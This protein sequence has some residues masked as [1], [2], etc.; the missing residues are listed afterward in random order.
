MSK[1]ITKRM[2]HNTVPTPM[3]PQISRVFRGCRNKKPYLTPDKAQRAVDS[4][5]K[6]GNDKNPERPLRPYKCEYCFAWHVGHD[7]RTRKDEHEQ[8]EAA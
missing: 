8:K 6:T 5:I 4:I 2:V 3:R 1:P 7:G